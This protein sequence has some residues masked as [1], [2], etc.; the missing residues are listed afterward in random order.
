VRLLGQ[1]DL[2]GIEGLNGQPAD[3]EAV[4]MDHVRIC[5]IPRSIIELLRREA[6]VLHNALIKRWQ[7]ALSGADNWITQFT[8][9]NSK[10]RVARLLLLLD[11]NSEDD[12]F[13]LPTRGDMGAMLGLTTE[14][15][16]KVTAELRR[17]GWL[18][19]LDQHRAWVDETAL[20]A[21]VD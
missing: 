6:P 20:Q 5:R 21:L 7:K 8:T 18:K 10:V 3:H 16:S 11:K 15:V 12:S 19:I 9:G 13:F 14:S 17:K 1:G 4:T 2:A